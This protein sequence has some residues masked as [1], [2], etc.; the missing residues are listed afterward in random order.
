L[1]AGL[2]WGEVGAGDFSVRVLWV[3]AVEAIG[4]V[5]VG[6]EMVSLVVTF[7]VLGLGKR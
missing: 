4:H 2:D 6:G 1:R 3:G 5:A 7:R